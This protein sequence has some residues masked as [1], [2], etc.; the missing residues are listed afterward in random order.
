MQLIP[1]YIQRTERLHFSPKAK[2]SHEL[3]AQLVC[4]TAAVKQSSPASRLKVQKG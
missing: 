2:R 4:M 3:D 1:D